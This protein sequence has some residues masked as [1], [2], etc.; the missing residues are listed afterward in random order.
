[1]TT[2][3]NTTNSSTTTYDPVS[4]WLAEIHNIPKHSDI[5][6]SKPHY[7]HLDNIKIILEPFKDEIKSVFEIGCGYGRITKFMLESFPKIEYYHATDLSPFKIE[8]AINYIPAHEDDTDARLELSAYDFMAWPSVSKQNYDLVIATEV[9]MHQLPSDI[10]RW[11]SKMNS[12]SKRY[13]MNIDYF[14]PNNKPT[15]ALANHNFLYDYAMLYKQLIPNCDVITR[16]IES[17]P[18]RIYLVLK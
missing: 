1:M 17:A 18:Q 14:E 15:H 12:I 2:T 5:L 16:K 7:D 13:I 9:L 6:N 8:E 4:Y 11:I 10:E 3:T